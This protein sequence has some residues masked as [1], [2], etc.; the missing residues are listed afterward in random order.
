MNMI[1]HSAAAEIAFNSAS[2]SWL[3]HLPAGVFEGHPEYL[4]SISALDQHFGGAPWSE[5]DLLGAAGFFRGRREAGASVVDMKRDWRVL[6]AIVGH[7]M[8][9]GDLSLAA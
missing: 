1:H 6:N 7:A 2:S 3:A 4:E 9:H 8:Q 5:A